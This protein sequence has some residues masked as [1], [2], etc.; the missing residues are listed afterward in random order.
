MFIRQTRT[1]NR[2]SGESYTTFRLVRS[3]RSG[4]KVRQVTLLNLG[5]GFSVPSA[6][7]PVLCQRIEE[8][9]GGQAQFFGMSLSASL[10]KS[11]QRY[12]GQLMARA[13]STPSHEQ[14]SSEKSAQASFQE[15]D[16]D[17][18][19]LLQPR[20]IGVEH[21]AIHAMQQLGFPEK[22]KELG[23]SGV[24]RDGIIGNIVARMARPGSEL[25][26]W[27][28][29]QH[30]SGLG[31]LIDV[32]FAAM[33]LMRLYRASD[34]LFK[35]KEALEEHLFGKIDSLF[36]LNE[37]VTLFDLTN[38][39]FEGE[40]KGN[41]KAKRGRSKE[42][43]SDCPLVTLGLVLDG[44]G[45]V[46]RSKTFA[47]NA[48]ECKTLEEML[49]GLG[50]SPGAMVIMDAGIA[51]E[52]NIQWLVEKEF[53]YIVV[54][55]SPKRQFVEEGAVEITNKAGETIRLQKELV[56]E[57]KEVLLHCFSSGREKKET[58]I[59]ER[60]C[61]KFETGL[62][63]IAEGLENP[64]GEKRVEVL[65]ERIG[66]LKATCRGVAKHYRVEL[67]SDG[68][69]ATE[70]V[71]EKQP[72]SGSMAT[73]PGV[74]CLRTN[75]TR[76]DEEKLWRTY[77]TLTDLESVFRSLKSE[78]GL[79]PVFHS[80]EGRADGHLFITV[81]AYQFVQVL[82]TQLKANGI[83]SS[84]AT[85]REILSVQRRVTVSFKQR[86]GK[87]LNVRKST[88]AEPELKEIYAALEICPAP[89][90]TK[91]MVV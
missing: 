36:A 77:I 72:V 75:E 16:V 28:W 3:E 58:G 49:N 73:H 12:A 82:R 37:T 71:F 20:S 10:E 18:Q 55:R 44:S 19:E 91:K 23:I 61:S 63:Q 74:Y 9:I 48:S 29:L 42:K 2:L 21:V 34:A 6:D 8:L 62:T 68:A 45:F 47:G 22:L 1:R 56:A 25:F 64:R 32:D 52:A 50:A 84:W 69:I 7:W 13:P 59:F 33:P 78:L 90:G 81:L 41:S 17:S 66:R 14:H 79:R 38:T 65:W 83:H 39:Y 30:Q 31:E 46:R 51:T 24:L 40:S 76:W 88:V 4:G 27:D 35:H 5:R 53:R 70:L 89:G 43:R 11:A 57:G 54:N 60:F 80:K 67:K 26:T 86:D 15:V 85:L 87:V